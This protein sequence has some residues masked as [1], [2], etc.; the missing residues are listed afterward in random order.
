MPQ[1]LRS[2]LSATSLQG[3]KRKNRNLPERIKKF[4]CLCS[5]WI[6]P[7]FFSGYKR[8]LKIEDI[9]KTQSNDESQGLADRMERQVTDML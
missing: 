1:K 4:N 9:Y 5:R 8:E 7:L 3:K 6:N 2:R